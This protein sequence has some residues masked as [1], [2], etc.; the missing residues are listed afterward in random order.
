MLRQFFMT[1]PAELSDAAR[2]DGA[3]EFDILFRI[4]LPLSRPALT[5]VLAVC[6]YR[7]LERLPRPAD[8]R[9]R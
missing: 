9:S 5:V 2:I 6:L 1:I 4:I 3:N 8:L 7:R